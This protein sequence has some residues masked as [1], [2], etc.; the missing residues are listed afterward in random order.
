MRGGAR[1]QSAQRK[2]PGFRFQVA[3]SGQGCIPWAPEA[4]HWKKPVRG[5]C[6]LQPG[7]CNHNSNFSAAKDFRGIAEKVEEARQR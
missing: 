6:H 1:N 4:P 7:T 5:T 2:V 3:G